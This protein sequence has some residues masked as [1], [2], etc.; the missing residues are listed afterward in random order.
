M[1]FLRLLG[2]RDPLANLEPSPIS[3]RRA[4]RGCDPCELVSPAPHTVQLDRQ[5]GDHPSRH[6]FGGHGDGLSMRAFARRRR[7][8]AG[9]QVA[10]AGAVE[11][12]AQHAL[13]PGKHW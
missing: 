12:G 10:Y 11:P 6:G 2:L 1:A 7:G 9:K 3:A 4:S 8:V 13:G 5:L